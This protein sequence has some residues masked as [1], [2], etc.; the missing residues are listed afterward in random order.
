[1]YTP[2]YTKTAPIGN[3]VHRHLV[4]AGMFPKLF[5]KV[6]SSRPRLAAAALQKMKA[7][8]GSRA[9]RGIAVQNR[10]ASE[11]SFL[12][13]VQE[14]GCTGVV[15]NFVDH[16]E[17]LNTF[18]VLDLSM[19]IVRSTQNSD[20]PEPISL[21][22]VTCG[23]NHA[24]PDVLP[25]LRHPLH[26]SLVGFMRTCTIEYPTADCRYIDIDIPAKRTCVPQLFYKGAGR[27]YGEAIL[28]NGILFIPK[29]VGSGSLDIQ[30][31]QYELRKGTM[32]QKA[33]IEA[34]NNEFR[35]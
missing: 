12:K 25:L 24:A 21:E 31:F 3:E 33:W 15:G 9:A 7:T 35:S 5:Q 6:L 14:S 4:V 16:G 11:D 22:L 18:D 1:M 20:P 23:S 29:L 19:K 30:P 32:R 27:F 10:L 26:G 34:E 2:Y 28:R 8:R 13:L 17:S